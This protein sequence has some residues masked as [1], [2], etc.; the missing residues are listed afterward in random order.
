MLRV[1][2]P[3][4]GAT[5]LALGSYPN[6]WYH[7]PALRTLPGTDRLLVNDQ[8]VTGGDLDVVD[9]GAGTV[10]ASTQLTESP[11]D[12]VVSPDGSEVLVGHWDWPSHVVHGYRLSDLAPT[13]TLTF[14]QQWKS[15]RVAGDADLL[16]LR[17]DDGRVGVFDRASGE[18]RNAIRFDAAWAP[19]IAALALVRGN[20]LAVSVADGQVRLF[21]SGEP[22]VEG[23]TITA[24]A[25]KP[26]LAGHP[27]TFS[28]TVADGATPL[29]GV[30]VRLQEHDGTVVARTVTGADGTWSVTHTW[31]TATAFGLLVV[32][33]AQA[34]HKPAV[35]TLD[36]VVEKVPSTLTVS[37]P[38]AV[39]P[40]TPVSL[41]GTLEADGSGVPDASVA[42]DVVCVSPY[43]RLGEG[44]VSTAADGTFA[45]D[46][47][48][49]TDCTD[50]RFGFSWVGDA[51]TGGL[52]RRPRRH[53]HLEP[54]G[55]EARG[56]RD[57]V[58]AR[59]RD[60]AP[61]P[62]RRRRAGR[63]S[64]RARLHE[65]AGRD[66]DVLGRGDGHRRDRRP[67]L[68]RRGEG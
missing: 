62:D 10:V 13:R 14:D 59:R 51:A 34:P 54:L 44:A 49:T 16:A 22:G 7:R 55:P 52:L 25:S 45:L 64:S 60:R 58:G 26:T 39:P 4:T 1:L 29:P 32:A 57:G 47:T 9:T 50:L 18:L 37:G 11:A 35:T 36:V 5:R 41:A 68:H 15:G 63:G 61:D 6:G 46:W 24:A 19:A 20:L 28:G 38:D 48:P 27:V 43:A 66:H 12:L 65:G 2:D 42:W 33:D 17:S 8:G 56:T 30:D 23:T 53:G 21:H 40:G 31:P 3:L 67:P